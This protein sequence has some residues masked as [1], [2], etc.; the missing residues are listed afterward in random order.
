MVVIY[1]VNLLNQLAQQTE[2]NRKGRLKDVKVTVKSS[3]S[4]QFLG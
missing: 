4:V 1:M 3:Q 2:T